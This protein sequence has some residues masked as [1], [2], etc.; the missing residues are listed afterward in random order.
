MQLVDTNTKKKKN[1][2]QKYNII[3]ICYLS[4]FFFV[5]IIIYVY[6]QIPN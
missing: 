3:E 6:R 1:G 2:K 4:M 5:T